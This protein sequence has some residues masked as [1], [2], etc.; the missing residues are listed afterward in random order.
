[1]D[2]LSDLRKQAITRCDRKRGFWSAKKADELAMKATAKAGQLIVS[3]Q[4]YECGLWHIGH[5]DLSD[6]LAH[7]P[8]G[9]QKCEV[10]KRLIAGSRMGKARRLGI[11]I[12]TCSKACQALLQKPP[13]KPVSKG[14]PNEG[15]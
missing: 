6:I 3:Y 9:K 1:M 12:T 10:C 5:A 7:R 4:C 15:F 2:D 11:R 8:R 14:P 13:T